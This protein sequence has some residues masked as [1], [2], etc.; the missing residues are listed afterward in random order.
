M[1]RPYLLTF[2]L[3]LSIYLLQS[4]RSHG[5]KFERLHGDASSS[6]NDSSVHRVHLAPR[7]VRVRLVCFQQLEWYGS[8]A[9]G[10]PRQYFNLKFDT[11]SSD[12]WLRS[13]DCKSSHCR[14]HR[15]FNSSASTSY[16]RDGR[17]FELLVR[18]RLVRGRLASDELQLG[19]ELSLSGQTFMEALEVEGLGFGAVR[20]D[21]VFGLNLPK[22]S[23]A[24]PG[25]RTPLGNLIERKLLREP[26]FGLFLQRDPRKSPDGELMFGSVDDRHFVGSFI[27][28]PLTR[29]D[30]WQIKLDSVSLAAASGLTT[31][32]GAGKNFVICRDHCQAVAN[33]SWPYLAGPKQQVDL[34]NR[35]LNA[36]RHSS[37]YYLVDCN[38]RTRPAPELIFRISSR[39]FKLTSAQYV[40]EAPATGGFCFTAIQSTESGGH[41][42]GGLWTLG[43]LFM[44]SFYTKFDLANRTLAFAQLRY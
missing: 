31:T 8:I 28:A 40:Q 11:G 41:D 10:N 22:G 20:S 43:A 14:D 6:A 37:G 15:R 4:T 26:L 23:R 19:G 24:P 25:V 7:V 44:S 21:G 30:R 35:Q 5:S 33:S 39:D 2:L 18:E 17:P 16:R 42:D 12:L 9:L 32:G 38:L 34:L 3:L 36:S 13:L 29:D 1:P 27:S